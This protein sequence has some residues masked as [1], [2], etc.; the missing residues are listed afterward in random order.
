MQN[1]PTILFCTFRNFARLVVPV[2]VLCV[3]AL[4]PL[5]KAQISPNFPNPIAAPSPL[6]ATQSI[7]RRNMQD[8]IMKA[9]E[10][11]PES[12]YS[13]RPTKDVRSFAEILIMS[14]IYP[15]FCVQTPRVK[16]PPPW[17]ARRVRKPRLSPTSKAHSTTAMACTL[18]SPMRTSM[19]RRTSLA[20]R[21]TRCSS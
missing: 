19:T 11:M 6:T 12:K 18:G 2:G 5:A 20:S 8:K 15:T 4:A 17:P 13:Y 14:G 16:R 7:F 9:A 10:A 1:F 3:F 21:R